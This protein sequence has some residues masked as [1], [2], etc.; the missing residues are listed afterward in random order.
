[1]GACGSLHKISDSNTVQQGRQ[2]ERRVGKGGGGGEDAG[3]E[4]VQRYFL[5]PW[6]S[7]M[8]LNVVCHIPTHETIT[9][10]SLN[11]LCTR[12][13]SHLCNLACPLWTWL[14]SPGRSCS[15]QSR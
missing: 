3:Q 15:T 7:D 5:E 13:G 12:K 9:A 2:D 8:L 6:P 1:M 4:Q 10:S 14:S 11:V